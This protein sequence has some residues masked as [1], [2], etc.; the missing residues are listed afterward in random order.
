[1]LT[2]EGTRAPVLRLP[3][4]YAFFGSGCLLVLEL[5]AG[6]L[7]A[8]TLGVSLYTWT[9]V[10]GVVLA[11][12][13]SGNFVG[14]RVADRHPSRRMLAVVFL[15][16]SGASMLVLLL[17]GVVDSLQL[18]TRVP[19]LINV[20]WIFGLLFFLPS[21]LL[22]AATPLLTRIALHSL[23]TTGRVVGRIQAAAT[24][25]SIIG[26]FLTGFVLISAMGTRLIVAAVAA[27]LLLLAIAAE[28]H[29]FRRPASG[30][31]AVLLASLI[32]GVTA[33]SKD[34]CTVESDYYCIKVAD[35][36]DSSGRN[37]KIVLFDGIAQGIADVADPAR[38]IMPYQRQFAAVLRA[39][40]QAGSK[41]DALIVGGG[42]FS[43]PRYLEQTYQGQVL[44]A[45][46]DPAVV[47]L[48]RRELGFPEPRTTRIRVVVDDARKV[49]SRPGWETFD[50]ILG[51]AFAGAS[52]PY[53][54]T[55][56]EYAQLVKAH[57]RPGGVYMLNLTDGAD[58]AFLRSEIAT[59]RKTFPYVAVLMPGRGWPPAGLAT[60]IVVL[61]AQ[62]APGVPLPTVP[63]DALERFLA[64]GHQTILTDDHVP[65]DQ[66][67]A[68]AIGDIVGRR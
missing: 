57:L 62:S 27:V 25:G 29:W 45:E 50:A 43:L 4:V 2:T 68:P 44:V 33:A 30:A 59:L 14:G 60:G 40:H 42:A 10:I 64:S 37:A 67:L 46:I 65:V 9:S 66:L 16:A 3:E 36:V 24:V 58:H 38:L 39:L 54:L 19:P 12:V 15:A 56:R 35:F 41:V 18:P 53:Q 21:A 26:T 5:V 28:P 1:M 55:T 23:D 6:R 52:V 51:D 11:G 49:L 47:S 63:Q 7:L 48:A 32:V 17:V 34:S 20:V 31:V 13:A 61:A 22:G 8:P